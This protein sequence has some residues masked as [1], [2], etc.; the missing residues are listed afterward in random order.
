MAQL[1]KSEAVRKANAIK[2][3]N[4]DFTPAKIKAIIE[5]QNGPLVFD[6]E[7]FYFKSTGKGSLAIESVNVKNAR[8]ARANT[9]RNREIRQKTPKRQEFINRSQVFFEENNLQRLD[10]KTARQYGID[11]Y[12][13]AREALKAEKLRISKAGLTAGHID[14]AVGGQTLERPGNYFAEPGQENFSKQNVVP[15]SRQQKALQTRL[16]RETAIDRMSGF[17][18]D[19]PKYTDQQIDATLKGRGRSLGGVR[20]IINVSDDMAALNRNLGLLKKIK[21]VPKYGSIM[22]ILPDIIQAI[23]IQTD[24]AIDKTVTDIGNRLGEGL[25]KVGGSILNTLKNTVPSGYDIIPPE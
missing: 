5:K 22:G 12:K 17:G 8:K 20:Q 24:G 4:P 7:P 23:D 16:P 18:Q 13:Q 2:I 19:L 14:P 9:T 1:T 6:G 3:A 11:Q 21:S 25:Q 15:T 10:G